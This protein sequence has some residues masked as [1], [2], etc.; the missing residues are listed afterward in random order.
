MAIQ[1]K[2]SSTTANPATLE[3]GELAWSGNSNVVFIGGSSEV[4]AVAGVRT[5][6]T[7][8]AN[9]SLVVDS[10]SFINEIKTGGLTNT[11]SGVSNTKIGGL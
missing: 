10:N 7:L 5:P 8:T 4:Y 2:R 6:G 9:Q 1:I 3:V 11:T